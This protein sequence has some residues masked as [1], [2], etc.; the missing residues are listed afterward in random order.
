MGDI[1]GQRQEGLLLGGLA[2]EREGAHGP[3]V[4]AAGGG[5]HMGPAGQPADLEG[6]LVGLGP[7][8]AEVHPALAAEEPEQP[9]GELDGRFGDEEVGDMAQFRDLAG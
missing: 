2:G 9:F 1:T 4:E 3:A 5:D 8:V 7:R 6:A